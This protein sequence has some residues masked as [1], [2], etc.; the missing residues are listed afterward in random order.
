MVPKFINK[1][2][3]NHRAVYAFALLFWHDG[4]RGHLKIKPALTATVL[5]C[6]ALWNEFFLE[7]LTTWRVLKV[8]NAAYVILQTVLQGAR[9][10]QIPSALVNFRATRLIATLRLV[11]LPIGRS[12]RPTRC[13]R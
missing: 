10:M 3:R 6:Y 9:A 13:G 4:P 1:Y 8:L 12:T 11:L 5:I 7:D 2:S